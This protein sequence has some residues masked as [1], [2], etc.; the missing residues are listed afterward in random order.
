MNAAYLHLILNHF[1]LILNIAALIVMVAALMW[2]NEAVTRAALVLMVATALFTVGT[3]MTGDGA[4]E[5]VKNM[6]G[7]DATA[8]HEHDDAAGFALGWGIVEGVFALFVLIRYRGGRALPRW[9]TVATLVTILFVI[10]VDARTS[11]LGGKIHHPEG[12]GTT[13]TTLD[14]RA[15]PR[16][17][18]RPLLT[19]PA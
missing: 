12:S 7:V 15:A 3:F 9:I 6:K 10:S 11:Y 1:P 8:I 18:P 19:Q 5:I 4:A 2:R 16:S 14:E 13:H 17:T